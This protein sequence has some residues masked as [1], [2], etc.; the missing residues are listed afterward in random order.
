ML[1]GMLLHN[2]IVKTWHLPENN[3]I[4]GATGHEIYQ[5]SNIENCRKLSKIRKY[6]LKT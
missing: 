4:K 5:N 6:P 1:Y 3:K 2:G